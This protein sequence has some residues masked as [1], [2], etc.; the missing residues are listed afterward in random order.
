MPGEAAPVP[1]I[2]SYPTM[3]RV[4]QSIRNIRVQRGLSLRSLSEMCGLN[5]NTL[6]LIENDRTSPGIGTL[7]QLADGLGVPITQ[8][9]PAAVQGELV[10]QKHG[11]RLSL[12]FQ[13][14]S[15]ENLSAG[16]PRFGAELLIVTIEPGSGSGKLP[17]LHTGRELVFCIEGQISYIVSGQAY[18][19]SPGDSLVFEA[20]LPHKWRNPG[21]GVARI[22]LVFC[23]MDT[24][25]SPLERHFSE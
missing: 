12:S 19:L 24:R 15:I 3:I 25:D 16:M 18:L 14:G 10:H 8:F 1:I 9:F 5:I 20:Y 13:H 2:E 4:G 23:P 7:Q 22:L 17:V 11:Q 6:S 21:A